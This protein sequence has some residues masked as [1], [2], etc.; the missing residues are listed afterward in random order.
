MGTW[1]QPRPRPRRGRQGSIGPCCSCPWPWVGQNPSGPQCPCPRHG[2]VGLD[3]LE[4]PPAG[5]MCWVE[6][7]RRRFIG[8]S[9]GAEAEGRGSCL[10]NAAPGSPGR[11][12]GQYRQGLFFIRGAPRQPS[13][14]SVGP[15]RRLFFSP[16]GISVQLKIFTCPRHCRARDGFAPC[17]DE[18]GCASRPQAGSGKGGPP[19]NSP[20]R[21]GGTGEATV[22]LLPQQ[23]PSVQTGAGAAGRKREDQLEAVMRL[24]WRVGVVCRPH[25]VSF[26]AAQGSPWLSGDRIGALISHY[27]I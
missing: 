9:V 4:G 24:R 10:Q 11:W 7:L 14:V 1:E 21:L 19:W 25:L 5:P 12:Q 13:E 15:P 22:L 26:K 23:Q 18:D 27:P 17:G 3:S 8:K 16:D 6:H 20:R 2:G